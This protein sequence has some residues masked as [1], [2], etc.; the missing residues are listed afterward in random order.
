MLDLCCGT[1]DLALQ[2][3]R[4]SK[5]S[6]E[7]VGLDFST[8]MLDVDRK[9]AGIS[10]RAVRFVEGNAEEMDF[11]DGYFNSV[12]IAFAFRNLTWRNSLRERVLAE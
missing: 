8:A 2:L 10:G 11:P 12:G 6:V 7:I 4:L 3:A 9:K 1:G 5:G